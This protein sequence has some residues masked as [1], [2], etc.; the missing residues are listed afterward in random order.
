MGENWMNPYYQDSAVTIYHGDCREIIPDLPRG[1]VVTDPPYNVGYHYESYHDKMERKDY[2]NMIC[3]VC[4]GQFVLIH[5]MED[6]V[7]LSFALAEVPAKVV[8]WVYPSNTA[9]QWRGIGWWGIK[10]DFTK[11]GQE[12]KNPTDKRIAE[13]ISNGEQARL[14]DWWEIDQVKNI[15]KEKT[16]HPCQIPLAV[17]VR[18]L[19]ITPAELVI[20]PFCGSGT[21]LR[22]AKDLGKT[23]IG[24]EMDERYCEIAASRMGQE[25]LA[26]TL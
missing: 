2:E 18:I 11:D 3:R 12:Y 1:L 24:I 14:Y 4:G 10:P 22:A 15:G 9:R 13:R 21:T 20:D 17:M 8:A 7:S 26:L 5:Y 25:V 16:D 19:K 23:A 6:L